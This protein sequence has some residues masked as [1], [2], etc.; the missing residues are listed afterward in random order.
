MDVHPIW[1]YRTS[2][3][4]EK[5]LF[6]KGGLFYKIFFSETRFTMKKQL[7]TILFTSM[8]C[9]ITAQLQAQ[10]YKFY[11]A[12]ESEDKVYRV[13]FDSE[14]GTSEI[15][16]TI[17][18]GEYP[19][20]IEGP[21]GIGVDPSGKYWYVSLGHGM[22]FGHLYKY[23]IGTDKRLG[24]V[25]LGLFPATLDISAET[26]WVY[27]VNFNLHGPH[28]PSSLSIV[29][30]ATMEEIERIET[31]VMPHGS[32]LSSDGSRQYHVSMMTDE[33][34]EI[35][36]F[37]MNVNRVLKLSGMNSDMSAEHG[38][39]HS[40]N[41]S[42]DSDGMHDSHKQHQPMIK[43]T[44]ASPNPLS[45][46][47]YVAG[48]G[49]DKIYV[50]NTEEWTVTDVWDSPGKAPYNLEP[51]HNGELLIV[52]YK[53]EGAVG[54]WDINR[55]EQLKKIST[56]RKVTHGVVIS[57]DDRYAFITSEGIG[58]ETGTIDIVDLEN[59][60]IADVIEI[61]KQA[62]GIAFWKIE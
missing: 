50:I 51:T 30:G 20:E 14:T 31:G 42:D 4:V 35:D 62:A 8:L 40:G 43:P 33:L 34:F 44:W 7:I 37:N 39:H 32:R 36:A 16:N 54:V 21:H 12:A 24:R 25:E 38:S 6:G 15:E 22:P 10:Q 18:V 17:L 1:L 60:E 52:T 26:G 2:L 55:G 29:D 53:G 58:G 45:N 46:H 27:V 59:M 23:E 47:V 13:S 11:V 19:T 56:S 28:E 61:G 41:S 57:P 5:S 48:N 3:L 9:L 49:D